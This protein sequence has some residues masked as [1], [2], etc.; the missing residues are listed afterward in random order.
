MKLLMSS[1]RRLVWVTMVLLSMAL[2]ACSTNQVKESSN[3]IAKL[4]YGTTNEIPQR[5]DFLEDSVEE[6][7]QK[8]FDRCVGDDLKNVER[9]AECVQIAYQNVKDAMKLDERPE[10]GE[11]II[12]QVADDEVIN[13]Q[14]EDN[15]Q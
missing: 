13:E 4:L 1:N 15:N 12:K 11:V 6:A 14:S 2:S 9:R 5:K 8:E 10:G 3:V 7:L